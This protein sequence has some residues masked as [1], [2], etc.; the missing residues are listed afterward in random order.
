MNENLYPSTTKKE[1]N[2][3]TGNCHFHPFFA[4]SLH[5]TIYTFTLFFLQNDPKPN[6]HRNAKFKLLVQFYFHSTHHSHKDW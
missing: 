3:Q 5:L 6:L 4:S 1:K 2:K